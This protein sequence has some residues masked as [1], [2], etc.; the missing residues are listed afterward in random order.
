MEECEAHLQDFF[1]SY[2]QFLD[3]HVIFCTIK[4]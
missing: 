4:N 2:F 3:D 1:E